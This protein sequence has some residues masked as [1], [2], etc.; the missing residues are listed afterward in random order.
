MSDYKIN[1]SNPIFLKYFVVI[2]VDLFKNNPT[3]KKNVINSFPDLPEKALEFN[4]NTS[5]NESH[6]LM[7]YI[8][9]NLKKFKNFLINEYFKDQNLF[10][11]EE[12]DLK[13]RESIMYDKEIFAHQPVY[14]KPLLKEFSQKDLLENQFN[15]QN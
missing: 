8:N 7:F 1:I 14:V 4:E 11:L 9:K 12:F 3:F 2:I 6:I 13:Y 10:S 15:W 5:W